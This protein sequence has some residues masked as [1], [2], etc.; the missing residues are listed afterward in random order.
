MSARDPGTLRAL[1][2]ARIR[3]AL[4]GRI[5]DAQFR[6]ILHGLLGLS[7]LTLIPKSLR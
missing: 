2:V 6:R 3:L 4:H 1:I 7:G 5:N